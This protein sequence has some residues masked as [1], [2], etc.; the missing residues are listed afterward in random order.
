[1]TIDPVVENVKVIQLS[2]QEVLRRYYEGDISQALDNL[3]MVKNHVS[4]LSYHL[5]QTTHQSGVKG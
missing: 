4:A 5:F 1:M 2:M 3:D